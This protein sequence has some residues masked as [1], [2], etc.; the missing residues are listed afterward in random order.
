MA[1]SVFDQLLNA[2]WLRPETALWRTIDVQA[3]ASFQFQSPSLDLGCGDGLFSFIRAGGQLGAA[4]DAFQ[5]TAN[6]D[7]FFQGVDV[8]DAFN[9]S[10]SPVITKRPEYKID[11]A[12]DHKESLLTRAAQLGLYE[13]IKCGD[14]NARL[15]FED[16]AFR[17]IFSNIVYW[18]DDPESAI[19]ELARITAPG[20]RI[21]LLLPN[22]SL[23]EFSFYAK[24]GAK[25]DS[26]WKFLEQLDRGRLAENIKHAKSADEW[27]SMF[28]KAGLRV[29]EHR[30]HLSKTVIQIW[31]IGLRPIF[32]LL[33]KMVHAI[34]AKTIAEIKEEWVSTMKHFLEPIAWMDSSLNQGAEPAFHCYT[35]AKSD[36]Q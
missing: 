28:K 19:A 27:E 22:R 2:Y 7:K 33:M 32:P 8:Y 14:A 9:A 26:D 29:E 21:C 31:D 11:C 24:L 4:Y 34:D 25:G 1:S 12:F 16:G 5:A 13:Q 3:M 23:P 35:L 6:L 20:G 18:L 36:R 15:P 10:A 17:S 30:Q